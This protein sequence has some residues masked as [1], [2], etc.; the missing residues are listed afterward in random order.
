MIEDLIFED[1]QTSNAAIYTEEVQ[2]IQIH[3]CTFSGPQYTSKISIL[4]KNAEDVEISECTFSSTH[5]ENLAL[6]IS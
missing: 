5:S 4:I 3:N 6:E 2:S 1:L